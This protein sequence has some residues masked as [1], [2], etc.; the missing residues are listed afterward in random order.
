MVTLVIMERLV[1][2]PHGAEPSYRQL[3][4]QLRALIESGAIGP[5]EPLPSIT[6][7]QQETGLAVGTIRHAIVL[8]ID[9]GWAYTVPGRGTFAAEKRKR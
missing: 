7:I 5:R 8:L 3:A 6:R 2:D 9:E 4:D 1:I